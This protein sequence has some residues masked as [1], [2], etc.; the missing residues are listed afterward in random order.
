LP[1]GSWFCS[2]IETIKRLFGLHLTVRSPTAQIDASLAWLLGKIDLQAE[3]IHIGVEDVTELLGVGP[4]QV[5]DNA[6]KMS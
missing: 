3:K 1:D 5:I 6:D 4:R 2:T